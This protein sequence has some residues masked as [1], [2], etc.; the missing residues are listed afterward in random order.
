MLIIA[1]ENIPSAVTAFSRFG[2]V[3]TMHGRHM[4]AKDVRDADVLLVR[5]ITRVNRELLA[6]SKVRFIGSATIGTDH[7][8]LDWIAEQGIVFA[9]APASNAIS[10]A[11]YVVSALLYVASRRAIDLSRLTA[12]IIGCG[13]VGSRV[14]TRLQA[15]G[16]QCLVC[17]PPRSEEEGPDGFVDMS[18][19]AGADLI[20]VHVPLVVEGQHRTI[21]LI[22]QDFL[23]SLSA[24]CIFINTSRGDVVD[25]SALKLKHEQYSSFRSILDVWNNEPL[26]DVELGG[27]AD[28]ATPHIAGYSIDG[29]LRATGMLYEALNSYL[30]TES[31]WS[32]KSMLPTPADPVIRLAAD[33]SAAEVISTCMN[34]V[35]D[36]TA[37]DQRMRNTFDLPEVE[38]GQAFDRLR[39]DY[40]M[41]RECS[42]Y[43]IDQA[44][45]NPEHID[46]L[47][48][49][50]FTLV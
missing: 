12:G 7:I 6:G 48:S 2:E 39:K 11:E 47:K 23:Q 35:Y 42:A 36:I 9:N 41:R 32:A 29:K 17:D 44:S 18:D 33:M 16:M 27:Y 10:A 28:I 25:E 14:Q 19:L 24:D 20:T 22:N 1:D 15:M 50:E 13:N 3:R 37:D 4:K 34:Q 38:R 46:L 31:S 8:D 26:I 43:R 49:F 5:S 40:P 30:G 21:N 45:I